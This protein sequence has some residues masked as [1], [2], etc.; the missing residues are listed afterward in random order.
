MY[1]AATI[2]GIRFGAISR[3]E[4]EA[5]TDPNVHLITNWQV[6]QSLALYALL[7]DIQVSDLPAWLSSLSSTY[8]AWTP[9]SWLKTYQLHWGLQQSGIGS[10]EYVLSLDESATSEEKISRRFQ[11]S[12]NNAK[13]SQQIWNFVQLMFMKKAWFCL[14]LSNLP[15]MVL[16]ERCG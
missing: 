6:L 1:F 5:S 7:P 16:R 14:P 3:A 12:G 13:I 11:D 4:F 10:P 9:R 8:H 15:K 2:F